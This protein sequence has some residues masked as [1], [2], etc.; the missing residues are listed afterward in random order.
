ME[1]SAALVNLLYCPVSSEK[2]IYDKRRG[3]LISKA[4]NLEFPIVDGIPLL[5]E[6]E[7]KPIRNRNHI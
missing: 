6:S 4:A 2:L 7:A 5:L 1:L 3:V